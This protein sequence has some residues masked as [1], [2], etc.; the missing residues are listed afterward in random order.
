[1]VKIIFSFLILICSFSGLKA[2]MPHFLD[3]KFILNESTAGK[4]AQ[5]SLKSRLEK[6]IQN[7]QA[8]EKSI[9]AEE[10]KIISQKKLSKPEEYKKKVNSLRS[11]V[12]KLQK[13]RNQLLQSTAEQRAKARKTLLKNLNPIIE[14]YMKDNK[15]RMVIDKKG[16]LLA[17]QDYD[18][19][20]QILEILNKELKSIKLD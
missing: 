18:I 16:I 14:K 3:F 6:G 17:D 11:K 15:I 12:S 20:K 5:D 4:K 13:E 7:L 10:A 9:Q 1:M 8:K 19:T 2:D